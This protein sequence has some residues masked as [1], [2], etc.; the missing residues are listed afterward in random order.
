MGLHSILSWAMGW[1]YGSTAPKVLC[2]TDEGL[3]VSRMASDLL[4]VGTMRSEALVVT[5]LADEE[6]MVC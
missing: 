4:S 2:F 5:A 3:V 1:W 6:L